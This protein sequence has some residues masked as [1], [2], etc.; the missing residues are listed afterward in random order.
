MFSRIHDA[1]T[2]FLLTFAAPLLAGDLLDGVE[3]E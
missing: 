1:M 3:E 2:R